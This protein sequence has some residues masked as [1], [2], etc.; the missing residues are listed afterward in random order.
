MFGE[1]LDYFG[2]EPVAAPMNREL[3]PVMLH[4]DDVAQGAEIFL[5][6]R[7]LGGQH[8]RSIGHMSVD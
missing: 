4:I 1:A 8:D 7:I 2:D 5:R 3:H 6:S